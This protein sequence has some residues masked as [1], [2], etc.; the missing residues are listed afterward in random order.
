MRDAFFLT[1]AVALVVLVVAFTTG[2]GREA[3]TGDAQS[4]QQLDK[5]QD[6]KLTR[7]ELPE[8]MADRIMAADTDGDGVV[9]QA[10]LEAAQEQTGGPAAEAGVEAQGGPEAEGG[11][12]PEGGPKPQAGAKSEDSPKPQAAA[13]AEDGPKPQGRAEAQGGPRGQGRPHAAQSFQELDKNQDGKLTRDELPERTADRIMAADTD[14][15]GTVTQA[16]LEAGRERMGGRRGGLGRTDPAQMFADLDKNQD[17]KLA[18]NELSE[19]MAERMMAADTNG[20]GA[21]TKA[22][23]EAAWEKRASERGQH[24]EPGGNN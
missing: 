20:D 11:A 16:E 22:E 14:G 6:G 10:E 3:G 2:C 17:G 24:G 8:Q 12:K 18:K 5:N 19:R 4:F 15:D 7:D 21:I 9:T 1:L 13:K 23:F